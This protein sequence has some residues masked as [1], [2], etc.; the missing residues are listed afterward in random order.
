VYGA[1]RGRAT[2]KSNY[3]IM[4]IVSVTALFLWRS[5]V[6]WPM[7][8]AWMIFVNVIAMK[9]I[10]G[11]RSK[12]FL[13]L[14]VFSIFSLLIVVLFS[15]K[16][17]LV[18]ATSTQSSWSAENYAKVLFYSASEKELDQI[19]LKNDCFK[20]LVRVGVFQ[21]I[22]NYPSCT[23]GFTPSAEYLNKILVL[24]QDIWPDGIPNFNSEKRL[25]LQE[26]WREFDIEFIKSNPK[27]LF[28]VL[29]PSFSDERRGS[30][31]QFLWITTDYKFLAE[32]RQSLGAIGKVWELSTFWIGPISLIFWIFLFYSHRILNISVKRDLVLQTGVSIFI[33]V[34]LMEYVFLEI[35]ENQRYR[36]EIEPLILVMGITGFTQF[37]R[38]L[39]IN[40]K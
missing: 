31:V 15:A 25:L 22:N 26:K 8:I 29:W 23:K 21:D 1:V 33:F 32:N 7:P 35:G 13:K 16:N 11:I 19:A 4:S 30:V 14:F 36:V 17:N 9:E 3:Y 40:K 2:G 5:S 34:L 38:C 27:V 10:V 39:E 12:R 20:E 6:V 37:L 18:F 28:R 24:N